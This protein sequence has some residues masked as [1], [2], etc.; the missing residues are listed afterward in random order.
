MSKA[1]STDKHYWFQAVIN[2]NGVMVTRQGAMV[3]DYAYEVKDNIFERAKAEW[4]FPI[5]SLEIYLMTKEGEL[6]N[7]ILTTKGM[8]TKT[9][10]RVNT[11]DPKPWEYGTYYSKR[12]YPTIKLEDT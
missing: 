11:P 2:R 7:L 9:I 8:E 3:A 12:N 10:T 6:G 4:K 1:T 5:E